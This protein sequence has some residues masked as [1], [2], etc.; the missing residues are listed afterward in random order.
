MCKSQGPPGA[1]CSQKWRWH[2]VI[3]RRRLARAFR[4]KGSVLIWTGEEETKIKPDSG[5]QCF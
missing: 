4:V 1:F 3:A 2:I 5:R